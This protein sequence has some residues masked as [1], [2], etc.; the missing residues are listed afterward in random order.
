MNRRNKTI[1][2]RNREIYADFCAHLRNGLP[3]MQ[4]YATCAYHYDLSEVNIR[5]IVAEQAKRK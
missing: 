2:C 4:A 5:K 1:E 3:T